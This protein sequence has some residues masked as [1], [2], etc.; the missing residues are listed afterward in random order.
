MGEGLHAHNH[1]KPEG[2]Q[3][4]IDPKTNN[5]AQYDI[6]RIFDF[7]TEVK[8][9][10]NV[11]WMHANRTKYEA[12]RDIFY[13]LSVDLMGQ[14]AQIDPSLQGLN[15]KQCIFRF[16]RDTRFS[17]DKS[18]YKTHFGLY[19]CPGGKKKVGA[20]YYLHLSPTNEDGEYSETSMVDVGVHCPPTAAA[21]LIR[22]GIFDQGQQLRTIL[23]GEALQNSGY[24]LWSEER[25]KVLPKQWKD[26]PY[27]D[28]IR[29]KNWDLVRPIS[30]EQALAPDFVEQVVEAFR[31]GKPVNDFFNSILEDTQIQSMF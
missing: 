12:A 21:R 22:Q 19:L 1:R 29:L 10:N 2:K 17:W 25:L 24:K 6:R 31:I 23:D 15:P 8:Y 30:D 14:M 3:T 27:D 20:G 4:N 26:S 13:A 16:A 5:M 7:L 18:P 11:E 28:L 9:N